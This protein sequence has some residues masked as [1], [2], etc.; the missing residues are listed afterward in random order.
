MLINLSKFYSGRQEKTWK[1][2]LKRKLTMAP[3]LSIR[4]F[5][6]PGKVSL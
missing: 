4:V 6:E 5:C 1:Y 2:R 3:E